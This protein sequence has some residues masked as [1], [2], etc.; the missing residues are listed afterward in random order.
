M[1]RRALIALLRQPFTTRNSFTVLLLRKELKF[2]FYYRKS[3]NASLAIK[4][5]SN[6]LLLLE[7]LQQLFDEYKSFKS[8]S[9]DKRALTDLLRIEATAPL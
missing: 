8:S 1:S 2:I 9:I 3:F 7:E 4:R 6:V 5:A